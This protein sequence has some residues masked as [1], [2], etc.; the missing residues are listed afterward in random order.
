MHIT[1]ACVCIDDLSM[2]CMHIHNIII[3]YLVILL[4]IIYMD[5]RR[6]TL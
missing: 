1:H 6:N 5:T 4:L 2:S 3:L